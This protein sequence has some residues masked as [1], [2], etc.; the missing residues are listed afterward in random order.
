M[1]KEI[2]ESIKKNLPQQVGEALQAE[3]AELAALRDKIVLREQKIQDLNK[4][5]SDYRVKAESLADLLSKHEEITKRE[6]AV[7]E[8]E[9]NAQLNE[10]KVVAAE[11]RRKDSL[12]LV[13]LVFRSPVFTKAVSGT[14]PVPVEATP[15]NNYNQSGYG[16]YVGTGPISTVTTETEV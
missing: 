12:E 3:L 15:P 14:I 6:S 1:Q 7:K 10:Y 13:K 8:R 2:L 9:L 5:A 16:A 11:E 4:L